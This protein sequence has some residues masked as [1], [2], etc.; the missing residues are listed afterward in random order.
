ME[1]LTAQKWVNEC[2][3]LFPIDGNTVLYQTLG[4]GVFELYQGKGQDKRIG[5]KKLCDKFEFNYKIYD[6][7]CNDLFDTIQKTWESDEFVEKNK[8]LGIIFSGYKGTG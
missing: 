4:S 3:I 6:V 7:G 1:N 5:L 2:G 8:N